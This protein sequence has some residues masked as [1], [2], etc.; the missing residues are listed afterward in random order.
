[1]CAT[2]LV[3]YGQW[4]WRIWT[5]IWLVKRCGARQQWWLKL[6]ANMVFNNMLGTFQP[7]LKIK[8]FAKNA[9]ASPAFL[10]LVFFVVLVLCLIF[11]FTIF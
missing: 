11:L 7:F 8:K 9:H 3:Q 6:V 4:T 1:M 5:R 10:T 2:W